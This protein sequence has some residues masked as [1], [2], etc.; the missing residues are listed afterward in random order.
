MLDAMKGWPRDSAVDILTR[1]SSDALANGRSGMVAHVD[2]DSGEYTLGVG[3]L[4]RM[5]IMLWS[6]PADK[7]VV[8]SPGSTPAAGPTATTDVIV[9]V[10]PGTGAAQGLVCNGA[11]EFVSDQ[12]VNDGA[13]RPND[14]LTSTTSGGNKGKLVKGSPAASTIVGLV[15]RGVIVWSNQATCVAFWSH[16]ILKY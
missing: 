15:S 13:I 2:P 9:P 1:F 3:A 8:G 11:Y 4:F 16:P 10:V 12:F 5:P 7:D 6:D 14:A